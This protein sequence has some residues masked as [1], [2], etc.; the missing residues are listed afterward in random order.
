MLEGFIF[1]LRRLWHH[2]VYVFINLAIWFLPYDS[3]HPPVQNFNFVQ[4]V[5]RLEIYRIL[6]VQ[7]DKSFSLRRSSP[8]C[9]W[10]ILDHIKFH[11]CPLIPERIESIVWN[12]TTTAYNIPWKEKSKS[13]IKEI[14]SMQVEISWYLSSRLKMSGIED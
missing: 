8:S 14:S 12:G 4:E 10:F 3:C 9:W 1:R 11:A 6:T 2:W 13:Q 5:T 7:H